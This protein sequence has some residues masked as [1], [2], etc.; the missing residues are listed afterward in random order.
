[1]ADNMKT[2]QGGGNMY[3]TLIRTALQMRKKAYCPYSGFSVGAALL[4]SDGTVY[5]GC[6]VENAAYS[7]SICAERTAFVKAVSDG[8]REFTAIAIA[9][10]KTEQPEK[11]SYPCGTC[12]QL[13]RE[14]CHPEDFKIITAVSLDDYRICTLKELLPESFGPGNL[15]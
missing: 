13:M 6:N 8:K 11:Y 9:G 2:D 4:C 14:F 15:V 7:V 10:G 5:T 1:M 12:R 3:D